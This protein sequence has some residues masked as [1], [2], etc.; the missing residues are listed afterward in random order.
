MPN[1]FELPDAPDLRICKTIKETI[2]QQH[3][4]NRACFTIFAQ[5]FNDNRVHDKNQDI[6]IGKNSKF[7][8][9]L[10]GVAKVLLLLLTIGIPLVFPKVRLFFGIR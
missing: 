10:I 8:H 6:E 2:I 7:R 1:K 5:E 3:E 9:I 4:Y